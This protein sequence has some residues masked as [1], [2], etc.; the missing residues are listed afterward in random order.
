MKIKLENNKIFLKLSDDPKT[1][2]FTFDVMNEFDINKKNGYLE[3]ENQDALRLKELIVKSGLS[4]DE[5]D[6]SNLDLAISK[7]VDLRHEINRLKELSYD[8]IKKVDGYQ[9]FESKILDKINID[10]NDKEFGEI[11]KKQI[12]KVF[13]MSKLNN[14]LNFSEPGSGKTL[15]T[16]MN[17]ATKIKD[18]NKVVVVSP[19]NSMNVWKSEIKKFFKLNDDEKQVHFFNDTMHTKFS[20]MN[21]K[22]MY[23]CVYAKFILVNYESVQKISDHETIMEILSNRGYHIVFDEAHRIKNGLS[24]RNIRSKRLSQKALSRTTLTGTPFSTSISEIQQIVEV[25]WPEGN[26]FISSTKFAEYT[27]DITLHEM[28]NDLT[29]IEELP[30][31]TIENIESL[32]RDISP[33]YFNLSKVKDFGIKKANDNYDNPIVVKPLT[34]QRKIDAYISD[35]ITKMNL[36]LNN[37]T[38]PKAEKERLEKIRRA[39]Y[40]AGEQN[41]VNPWL[42]KDYIP[43][44]KFFVGI[45]EPEF[46]QLPKIR[47]LLDKVKELIN[48]DKK[49]V[50]WFTFVKNIINF[51]DLLHNEGIVAE[52]IHGETKHDVR[53]KI[54][55]DFS[56][57]ES[58]I[59]VLISNPATIAESIS[60]HKSVSESIF[61]E[62]TMSYFRWAQAKDRVH[63]VGSRGIVNH[64]YIMNKNLAMEK[65]IFDNLRKKDILAQEI[66]NGS[67]F[68]NA[69]LIQK[70]KFAE[71]FDLS[72]VG[73]EKEERSYY[74]N[75]EFKDV[76]DIFTDNDLDSLLDI[77][78]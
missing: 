9:D 6:I 58:K 73:F 21:K 35:K 17:L 37:R 12:S 15:M 68:K 23:D 28:D 70:L 50:V 25:T 7:D 19:I 32:S 14:V 61:V 48:S 43:F 1:F 2:K 33:L 74:D 31:S 4:F 57:P 47:G 54:I 41:L 45:E 38:F 60:L 22:N 78:V 39:L 34:I 24:I 3:I 59:Q 5:E 26:P 8:E 51:K 36:L 16:L 27:S 75:V 76:E 63:R 46:D 10:I 62:R 56:R 52:E 53:Q 65:K 11:T 29:N 18:D 30:Q 13:A 71:E 67:P 77:E 66:F 20:D 64:N 44:E 42:L 72:E 55:D 49:V 69:E 40:T